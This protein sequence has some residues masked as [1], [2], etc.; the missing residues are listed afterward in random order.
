[1]IDAAIVQS[2]QGT[3]RAWYVTR[4][5]MIL[6]HAVILFVFSGQAFSV[7]FDVELWPFSPYPMYSTVRTSYSLEHPTLYAVVDD[8]AGTEILLRD[9]A[10]FADDRAQSQLLLT[11]EQPTADPE[12]QRA[13]AKL[14]AR[15]DAERG[16]SAEVG[17][18]LR[19]L[20]L[21]ESSWQ[22]VPG[23]SESEATPQRQLIVEVSGGNHHGE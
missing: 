21:Y 11:F 8:A 22:L 3:S 5:R 9:I 2:Q 18:P 17:P 19:G 6:A 1:M 23:E 13:L 12:F 15:Y 16:A 20:R 4:W 14:L 7:L 10:Y